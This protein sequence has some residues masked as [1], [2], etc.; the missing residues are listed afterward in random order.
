[1]VSFTST[2]PNKTAQEWRARPITRTDRSGQRRTNI[3]LPIF[4]RAVPDICLLTVIMWTGITGRPIFQYRH[5]SDG[6]RHS[7]ELEERFFHIFRANFSW[8]LNFLPFL[9][10]SSSSLLCL[11]FRVFFSAC[12][13]VRRSIPRRRTCRMTVSASPARTVLDIADG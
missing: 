12:L 13:C 6:R 10:S 9:F 7:S 8:F 5:A 2:P 11:L 4:Y 1:M 3:N